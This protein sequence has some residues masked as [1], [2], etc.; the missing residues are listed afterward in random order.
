MPMSR[1]LRLTEEQL[2]A[3]VSAT[4]R[5]TPPDVAEFIRE[6]ALPGSPDAEP[7]QAAG[8]RVDEVVAR[9][10][11]WIVVGYPVSANRYWRNFAGRMVMSPEAKRYKAMVA[12]SYRM[13]GGGE[14]FDGDVSVELRLH[15]RITKT[16][17]SSKS[18]LD[19]DNCIKVAIDALNRIAYRDDSQII[20]IVAEIAHP[21]AGGALSVRVGQKNIAI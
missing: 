10:Q 17:A 14:Y 9:P 5:G 19:L 11:G 8:S 6:T 3:R 21:V 7:A 4:G 16:G 20:R 15:P 12:D 2:L 1:V 18:R 13:A